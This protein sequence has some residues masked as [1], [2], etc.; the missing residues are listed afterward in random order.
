MPNIW[1]VVW[2]WTGFTGAPGYTNLYYLATAGDAGEAF[3]AASKSRYLFDGLKGQLPP[4]V[5]MSLVTD[6]RLL[7]D[8]DGAL[9]NIFTVAGITPVQ[10]LAPSGGYSAASGGCIDWLTGAVHGRHMMTGR[11]F[12]VPLGSGEYTNTGQITSAAVLALANAGETMRTAAGPQ[13]GVWGRP[14]PA[15]GTV[16][17]PIP[18]LAGAWHPAISSRVPTKAVVLRSRRD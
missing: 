13:F 9:Q 8:S 1:Q 7:R 2:Q 14:R 16:D 12:V 15:G 5:N 4:A 6:V 17:K 10:G 18:A 11:T 3:N